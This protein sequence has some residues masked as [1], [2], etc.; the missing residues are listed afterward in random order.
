MSKVVVRLHTKA[1][2]GADYL[3]F[4]NEDLLSLNFEFQS[5]TDYSNPI[6]DTYPSYGTIEIEDKNLA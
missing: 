5:T 2:Q 1:K 6:Y 3:D 4:S